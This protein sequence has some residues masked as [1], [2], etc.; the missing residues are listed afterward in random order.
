LHGPGALTSIS[1]KK[2]SKKYVGPYDP[3][4]SHDIEAQKTL[5]T[6]DISVSQIRNAIIS[7]NYSP[8]IAALNENLVVA[9]LDKNIPSPFMETENLLSQ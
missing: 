1:T 6:K 7:Y 2:C 9:Q 8:H 5:R 3:N 4:I